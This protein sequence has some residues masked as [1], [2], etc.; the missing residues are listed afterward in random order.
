VAELV[1]VVEVSVGDVV[2]SAVIEVVGKL[3][4]V[5][6]SKSGSG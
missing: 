2:S 3:V 6:V 1:E 4:A 5:V